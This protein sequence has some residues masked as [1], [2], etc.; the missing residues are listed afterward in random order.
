MAG[1]L[2]KARRVPTETTA[3][4]GLVLGLVSC[5]ELDDGATG[6]ERGPLG[7]GVLAR[8]GHEVV[9]VSAVAQTA[10]VLA[11]SRR[12]ALERAI[13]DCLMAAEARARLRGHGTVRT[14]ERALLARAMLEDIKARARSAGPPT[15]EELAAIRAHEWL[16]FDR[17]PS[18]RTTH[19]VVLVK[20]PDDSHRS[21][22]LAERIAVAVRGITDPTEFMRRARAVE[23]GGLEVKAETLPPVAADGRVVNLDAREGPT[24]FDTRFAEAANSIEAVGGQSPVTES[25]FGWHVI[26]LEERLP[27]KRVSDGQLRGLVFEQ[28]VGE[29]ARQQTEQLLNAVKGRWVVHVERNA[30]EGMGLVAVAP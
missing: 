15:D 17:P 3:L 4:L 28:V 20:T 25:R 21:R 18:V 19:V 29:R 2:R 10:R 22:L 23:A 26:L 5:G 16:K 13:T 30:T 6:V 14:I 12:E 11:L 9:T 7:Q 8:V 27:E 24:Q 1:D